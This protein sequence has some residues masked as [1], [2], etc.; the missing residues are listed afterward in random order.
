MARSTLALILAAVIVAWVGSA[1]VTYGVVELAGGGPRGEEGPHGPPGPKGS[2]GPRGP[3]G[4]SAISSGD[5]LLNFSV[6]E[7]ATFW[8]VQQW[9][10]RLSGDVTTQHPQVQACV[11][12]IMEPLEGSAS[13]CGFYEVEP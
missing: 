13:D 3:A 6:R 5:P 12:Y 1:A 4:Q 2:A 11:A 7:L 10:S 9:Q 8:A